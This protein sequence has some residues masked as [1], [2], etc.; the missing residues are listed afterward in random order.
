[1]AV[2]VLQFSTLKFWHYKTYVV[3]E[4]YKVVFRGY[5]LSCKTISQRSIHAVLCSIANEEASNDVIVRSLLA[6][7]S[8]HTDNVVGNG[9]K[10]AK[11]PC[12]DNK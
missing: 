7:A 6:I 10:A 9:Q 8:K 4:V 3:C 12:F 1:M 2:F 5:F 11:Y